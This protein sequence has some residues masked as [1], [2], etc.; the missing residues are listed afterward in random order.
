VAFPVENKRAAWITTKLNS[1]LHMGGFA[2]FV[3][4]MAYALAFAGDL[5]SLSPKIAA[6]LWPANAFQ[7]AVMLLLPRRTWPL[8]ITAHVVGGMIHGFQIHLTPL[9]TVM[10]TLA[11]VVIFV[12]AGYGLSREFDGIPRLDSF[13][14]FAKY[15]LIAVLLAPGISALVS[16]FGTPGL[17][18]TSCRIWFLLNAL[19]LLTIAP[20]IF[21]WLSPLPD[22]TRQNP[23]WRL[24][25]SAQ[26]SVVLLLG[27]IIF[28]SPWRVTSPEMFYSLVP[29]LLW[30][31]LRFGSVGVST[32]M[33]IVSVI[34][35]WGAVHGHGP[36]AGSDPQ[37]NSLSLL[38]FLLF[39]ATLFLL[40]AALVEERERASLIQ[41]ALSRRLISAQEQERRRIAR[42]LHDDISQKLAVLSMEVGYANSISNG[43]SV[44]MKRCLKK[45]QEHCADIA[46]ELH[47]LSHQLHSS[48][49]EYLGVAV[50]IRSFC[51][52]YSEV[53]GLSVEFT[54]ESVPR[55]LPND[56][57]LC[58]FRITQE[59]LSNARKYSGTRNFTVELRGTANEIRLAVRDRGIGFDVEQVRRAGGLGLLSMDERVHL[60]G[61][62]LS[63]QSR[64]GAGT[65]ILAVVP[66]P[67]ESSRSREERSD[68]AVT[69][70]PFPNQ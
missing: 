53:H 62:N 12:I 31:A 49:L 18:W 56:V 58:L 6:V 51:N 68:P 70:D 5:F 57:A 45:A 41:K 67:A 8:L 14:A 24:E 34:S 46:D 2:L 55:H 43:S 64:P 60:V 17:Y 61:G 30:A 29:L 25:A 42:E 20:A 52:E 63:I 1:R 36:F 4:L 9:M 39:A 26:L 66:L 47:S 22:W 33:V 3:A 40:L 54:D 69:R 13:K 44:D 23:H 10:F 48:N 19:T 28:L 38:L 32:S 7:V 15:F 11:D 21:G 50:A 16:G 37:S 59:T 35:V 27:Y 65:A